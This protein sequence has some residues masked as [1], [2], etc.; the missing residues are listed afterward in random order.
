MS[1][2]STSWYSR[3]DGNSPKAYITNTASSGME[4][5]VID[6]CTAKFKCLWHLISQGIRQ[7]SH[8]GDHF[9]THK[10]ENNNAC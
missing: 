6:R 10:G 4:I 7:Q 2:N 5:T 9:G 1:L 3:N 8:I